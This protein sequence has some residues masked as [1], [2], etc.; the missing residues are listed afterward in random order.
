MGFGLKKILAAFSNVGATED[1]DADNYVEDI[2]NSID[3]EPFAVSDRN[4]L[5]ASVS[6]LGG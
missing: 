2:I 6:E 3:Q 4:V 5:F 1:T